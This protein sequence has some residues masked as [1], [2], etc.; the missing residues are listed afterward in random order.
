MLKLVVLLHLVRA[1]GPSSLTMWPALEMRPGS[2]TVPAMALAFIIAY[3]LKMLVLFVV[4]IVS[5]YLVS[6]FVKMIIYSPAQLSAT[7]A[8]SGWQEAPLLT[9]VE[10]RFVLMRPGVQCVMTSGALLM[11][12]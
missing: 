5:L 9:L 4:K 3:I 10:W 8:V 2:L 1:L 6:M 11:L 7:M 12:E